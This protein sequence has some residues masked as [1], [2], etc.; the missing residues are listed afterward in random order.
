MTVSSIAIL[1]ALG[2][3]GQV[4]DEDRAAEPGDPSDPN[5]PSRMDPDAP[6]PWEPPVIVPPDGYRG[7]MDCPTVE[8]PS[9]T[10]AA[11][12]AGRSPAFRQVCGSCHGDTGRG[13]GT[14]PDLT[15]IASLD[16]YIA[17]VREGRYDQGMPSFDA[18]VI[19]DD[20]LRMDFEALRAGNAAELVESGVTHPFD[21]TDEEVEAR[22]RAGLQAFRT[23]DSEGAA[24]ANCHAPD[25]IDLAILSYSDADLRRRGLL[26]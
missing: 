12:L 20:E 19:S 23:P 10:Q 3:Q 18:S 7:V 4:M 25:G 21:W 9:Y 22:Y 11:Q 17:A 26:H 8:L 2:C 16:Q 14:A 13:E 1:V 6:S 5:R 24:C 15:E